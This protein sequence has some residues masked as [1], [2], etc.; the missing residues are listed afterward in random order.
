MAV[1]AACGAEAQFT[2]SLLI[3]REIFRVVLAKTFNQRQEC[4]TMTRLE[5]GAYLNPVPLFSNDVTVVLRIV[6]IPA[7]GATAMEIVYE[8]IHAV[9]GACLHVWT[10]YQVN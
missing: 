8:W 2:D 7:D 4:K 9:R 5:W 10:V 3:E 1:L 6:L